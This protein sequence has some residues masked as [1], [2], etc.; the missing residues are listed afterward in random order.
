MFASALQ[1]AEGIKG[2]PAIAW[3]SPGLTDGP[4]KYAYEPSSTKDPVAGVPSVMELINGMIATKH[5]ATAKE[6][7]C[8]VQLCTKSETYTVLDG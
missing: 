3:A 4:T 1:W 7:I 5:A 6:D 2:L 8:A